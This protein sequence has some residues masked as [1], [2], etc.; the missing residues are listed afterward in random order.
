M[1][2]GFAPAK[3]N[4]YLHVLGRR[5]DGY[6]LI[7]S[8]VGFADIGDD[9]T[10][11]PAAELSLE[12]G[13]PEAAGLAGSG[14]DN[15][16]LRAARLLADHAGISTGAALHLHKN[17]PVASG[18]GGGSSD[19]A[20]AMR[21][22]CQLWGLAIDQAT[23][24]RLGAGLGA[25]IP[26]CL[27][28]RAAWVGGIGE[29][30]EPAPAL[31]P[32]GIVLANPRAPLPTTAVFAARRGRFGDPGR[33]AP[34]P[35]DAAGLAAA[36][37]SCGN[38]LTEAA[39]SR[40]PQIGPVLEALAHLPGALIA[41]MTGSGATCF[42]LFA[43]G[44]RAIAARARLAAAEPLWWCAAGELVAGRELCR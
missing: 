40:V 35:Q 10:A 41:R 37:Q 34:M 5:A 20:A 39:I 21:L 1:V 43:D 15:L 9:L 7:D 24:S 38:Q 4:L 8:L 3:V 26:V 11:R 25:D 31:P 12:L 30:I 36:L 18:I 14:A 44:A 29:R 32:A 33:F 23:L 6:H 28:A 2:R 19:A 17:L 42:A 22:L 13:G 16:V 27:L